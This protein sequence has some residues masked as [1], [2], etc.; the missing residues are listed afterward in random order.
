MSYIIGQYKADIL[1]HLNDDYVEFGCWLYIPKLRVLLSFQ[2][3]IC[4]SIEIM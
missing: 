1:V 2:R 4:A 3:Q